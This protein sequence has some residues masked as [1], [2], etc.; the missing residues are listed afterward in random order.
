MVTECREFG[1]VATRPG[2]AEITKT[3]MS[4]F[5]LGRR[6]LELFKPGQPAT[7]REIDIIPYSEQGI[8]DLIN[9]LY[10]N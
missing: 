8:P 3:E 4:S 6:Q 9:L 1:S 2:T 7:S 5:S 10:E